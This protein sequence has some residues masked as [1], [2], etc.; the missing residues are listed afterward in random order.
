MDLSLAPRR[1]QSHCSLPWT[2]C[3]SLSQPLSA[4]QHS[5]GVGCW[6]FSTSR[7][8]QPLSL[9]INNLC[10]DFASRRSRPI[11]HTA[12]SGTPRG[13]ST[14][15]PSPKVQK[16]EVGRP[17]RGGPQRRYM[18]PIG[19]APTANA[20]ARNEPG[21]CGASRLGHSSYLEVA[22]WLKARSARTPLPLRRRAGHAARRSLHGLG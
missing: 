6:A 4:P 16:S 21:V 19:E 8:Q 15:S 18:A 3:L 10:L 14:S 22:R 5:H 12:T 1:D 11:G 20:V 9:W 13:P 2:P 17:D 7:S